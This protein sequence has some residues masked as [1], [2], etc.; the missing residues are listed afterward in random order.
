MRPIYGLDA[1]VWD[2]VAALR[3]CDRIKPSTGA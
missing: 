2:D 1:S 3:R